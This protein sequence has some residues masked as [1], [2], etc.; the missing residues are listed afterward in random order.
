MPIESIDLLIEGGKAAPGPAVAQKLGPAGIN[1]GEVMSRINEKTSSFKGMQVPV[2]LKVDTKT[3]E[4]DIEVGVPPTTQLIKK[5]LNLQK[6]ASKPQLE[7]VANISI[8]QCI[9]VAKMKIENMYTND[10]KKAVKSVMGSCNSLGVLIEGKP[11]VETIKDVESGKYDREI[12]EERTEVSAEK[13]KILASQL[14]K[15]QEEL[16]KEIERL[17]LA[18]K[19]AE[20]AKGVVKEEKEQPAK[21]EKT[22]VQEEKKEVKKK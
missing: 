13:K 2:K 10:L 7:K 14:E 5:E 17:K 19:A 15:V 16:N 1:I 12:S 9:N 8:E 21:E 6:G 18:Q 11:A 4:V 3:K 22:E 20:E